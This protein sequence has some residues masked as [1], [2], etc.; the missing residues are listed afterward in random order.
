MLAEIGESHGQLEYAFPSIGR[1]ADIAWHSQKIVFEIQCSPIA[2]EEAKARCSDYL[3]QGYR[4]VWIL[5][6][7]RFNKG[8]L[9]AAELFLRS[10][11]CY[12]TDIDRNGKGEVYDQF[13]I[14]KGGRRL[15]KGPPLSVCLTQIETL[16]EVVPPD[17]ALPQ[18][19]LERLSRWKCYARGDLLHR[20]LL[21]GNLSLSAKRMLAA[22]RRY[23]DQPTG[24]KRLPFRILIAKSYKAVLH[25]FL[26]SLSKNP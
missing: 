13:E 25:L 21:E 15:F 24:K 5:H 23:S 14:I 10:T 18:I 17:L 26:K 2:A 3:S 4:V 8:Q 22:E 19:V 20:L 16:P 7:K 12:F 9:S 1:I 11:P 6:T